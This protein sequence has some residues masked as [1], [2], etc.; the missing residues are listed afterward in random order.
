MKL[1]FGVAPTLLLS[2]LPYHATIEAKLREASLTADAQA[3]I[4]MDYAALDMYLVVYLAVSNFI[5]ISD[6]GSSSALRLSQCNL[7]QHWN[8]LVEAPPLPDHEDRQGPSARANL[9]RGGPQH[10]EERLQHGH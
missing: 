5:Q 1:H 9:H 2:R 8:L 7:N 4:D 3:N 10:R 6:E